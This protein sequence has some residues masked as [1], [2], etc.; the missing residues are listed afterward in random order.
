IMGR[1]TWESLQIRPLPNRKNIVLSEDSETL[2]R[3]NENFSD[4]ETAYSLESALR[5]CKEQGMD[6]WIIGGATV[7]KEA[8][9]RRLVD[10]V[11]ATEIAA[12]HEGDIYFPALPVGNGVGWEV[13]Q[14]ASLIPNAR[15]LHYRRVCPS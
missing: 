12:V 15:V 5:K 11:Y 4:V 3:I 13:G 2:R 1:K 10:E 9:E 6:P 7:Y 8:L 14:V